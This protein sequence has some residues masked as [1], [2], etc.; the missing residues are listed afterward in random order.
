[1]GSYLPAPTTVQR[2]LPKSSP[3]P[4]KHLSPRALDTL[5]SLVLTPPPTQAVDVSLV[6]KTK[7]GEGPIS[8]SPLGLGTHSLT[9][10]GWVDGGGAGASP[11]K[12]ATRTKTPQVTPAPAPGPA[13]PAPP[14]CPRAP[15]G[16]HTHQVPAR[17][18]RGALALRPG[19]ARG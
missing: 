16:A 18:K 19:P 4:H 12:A 3:L 11:G 8:W 10:L 15:G 5:P 14:S 6:E 2:S 1:M 17:G 13:R 9:G 7:L